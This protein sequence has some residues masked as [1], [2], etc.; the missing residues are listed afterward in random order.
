MYG[1]ITNILKENENSINNAKIAS[2]V[3]IL[4]CVKRHD[5]FHSYQL[6]KQM[7]ISLYYINQYYI[8]NHEMK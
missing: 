3:K 7:N 6:K 5:H 1:C 4:K 2:I 8:L